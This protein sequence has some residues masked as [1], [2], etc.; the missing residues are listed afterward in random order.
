M[1]APNDHRAGIHRHKFTEAAEVEAYLKKNFNPVRIRPIGRELKATTIVLR[2]DDLEFWS[3]RTRSGYEVL[4]SVGRPLYWICMPDRGQLDARIGSRI[5]S[6]HEGQGWIRKSEDIDSI[7][8]H[9]GLVETSCVI[10]RETVH[11]H[12][13]RARA[14]G[15]KTSGHL[16]GMLDI[17]RGNGR[18]ISKLSTEMIEGAENGMTLAFSPLAVRSFS[19]LFLDL[20]V[21]GTALGLTDSPYRRETRT[22]RRAVDFIEA[23]LQEPLSVMDIAEA[24]GIGPRALQIGFQR[25]YGCTPQRYVRLLRLARARSDLINRNDQETI[26]EIAARWGFFHLGL[27]A[28][29]YHDAYRERPSETKRQPQIR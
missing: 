4:P 18:L 11:A 17:T 25:M 2:M 3:I 21:H 1:S 28:R 19:S 29:Q 7:L 26:A 20:L 27:F 14:L 6:V 22:I 9:R 5:V 15:V 8:K 16:D 24:A 12:I 13:E 23:N 10:P